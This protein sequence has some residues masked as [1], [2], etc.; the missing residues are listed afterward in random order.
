MAGLLEARGIR[1]ALTGGLTS[2]FYRE[3]RYTQD[4]DLVVSH[5][6]VCRDLDGQLADFDHSNFLFS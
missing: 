4:A 6:D 3:P 5:D 1:F 2:A